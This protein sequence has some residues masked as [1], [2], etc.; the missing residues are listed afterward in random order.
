MEQ[1]RAGVY[2]ASQ[3]IRASLKLFSGAF[4]GRDKTFLKRVVSGL[5][6]KFP[7]AGTRS[8]RRCRAFLWEMPTPL[9]EAA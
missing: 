7:R 1:L 3:A 6:E 9:S 5:P 4:I 2:L 8:I